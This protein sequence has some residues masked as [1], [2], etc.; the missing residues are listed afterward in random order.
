MSFNP[1]LLVLEDGTVFRGRSF[2][3]MGETFGEAVFTTGMTGYQE[4]L[5]D[6]SYYQQI[7]IQTAPHIGNTGI[8]DEDDESSRI[9]VSGYVVRDPSRMSS[10]WR[11]KR[12][13]DQ[14]LVNQN[15]VGISGIDTTVNSYFDGEFVVYSGGASTENIQIK[16]CK[17][18]NYSFSAFSSGFRGIYED[19]EANEFS[20]GHAD[21]INPIPTGVLGTNSQ[22]FEN[23][24]IIKNCTA[25][26]DSFCWSN[27]DSSGSYSAINYGTIDG[28]VSVGTRS[29]CISWTEAS[30]YGTIKNCQSG[31]DS[32]VKANVNTRNYGTI[33][34]CQIVS[35]TK[36]ESFVNSGSSA[37][38][39]GVILNCSATG[40]GGGS[41]VFTDTS[42]GGDNVGL[43]FNCYA[44][45]YVNS[46]CGKLGT[47]SGSID[48]CV[49]KSNSFCSSNI[50]NLTGQIRRCTLTNGIFDGSLGT[51]GGRVM[52]GIDNS[53]VVNIT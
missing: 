31:Q 47:N 33:E 43:I 6:P 36:G 53:G 34:N 30:N 15:I 42:A 41:F 7:V 52:L 22:T 50:E 48:N 45:N 16:N 3:Q 2:G 19:C 8:N 35:G 29:F 32:F 9:W 14:E 23:Y 25:V 39:E 13:L 40:N 5:T 27:I 4:T 20:F 26:S 21:F 38:N 18:R 24:G 46:F 1:A 10:N 44:P 37:I 12:T 28:C 51:S 49:A 11:S 17:G